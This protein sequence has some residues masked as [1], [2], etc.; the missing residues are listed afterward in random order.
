MANED[1]VQ[2]H[3][4]GIAHGHCHSCLHGSV[5]EGSGVGTS[6]VA[7]RICAIALRGNPICGGCC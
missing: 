3:L 6:L 4:W 5:V 1:L 7:H 2:S